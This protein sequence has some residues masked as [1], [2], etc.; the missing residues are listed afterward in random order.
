MSNPAAGSYP[1][2][3]Q[4]V[5]RWEWLCVAAAVF[6]G[7]ILRLYAPELSYFNLHVERDLYRALQLLTLDEIPLLGS[8]M[9][10]GGRVFGP[11]IYF[12]YAI[13]LAFSSSP[14]GVGIFIGLVNTG[15]LVLT[16][17]FTRSYFSPAAG[18]IAAAVYAVFPLEVVQLR[19]LWNPTFL[20]AMVLG[21]YWCLYRYTVSGR[22]WALVGTAAFFAFAL[23]LHFSIVMALPAVGL[24]LYW[25]GKLPPLRPVLVAAAL[26]LV[27]FLPMITSELR[28]GEGNLREVIEAPESHKSLLQRHLPNPNA[29]R[30][31]LHVVTFDWHEDPYRLG[32]TYL[33]P[34]RDSLKNGL[35][36]WF[37]PLQGM[38]LLA[39]LLHLLFWLCGIFYIVNNALGYRRNAAR[40][41]PDG[42]ERWRREVLGGLLLLA[43]QFSPLLSLTFFNYHNTMKEGA[44]ALIPIRYYLI[45]FPAPFILAGIGLR[46]LFFPEGCHVRRM[47]GILG[48]LLLIF[49]FYAAIG[50]AHLTNLARTGIA[51]PYLSYHAPTLARMLE[52]REVLLE[53]FAISDGDYY[54]RTYTWNVFQPLAGEATMDYLVTQDRRSYDNAGLAGDQSI[55]IWSPIVEALPDMTPPPPEKWELRLPEGVREVARREVGR[56]QVLLLEGPIP[57]VE[58]FDPAMKRNFY[59][60]E[61]R[62]RFLRPGGG[63]P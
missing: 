55:L 6:V 16:W 36:G 24:A 10:Y 31:L 13:P 53:E 28:G 54:E 19:Y 25:R 49:A 11:L 42:R 1:R 20:P 51:L 56:I 34:L 43:W 9:Q 37:I 40:W 15:M 39:G 41:N 58:P 2:P 47:K 57:D 29:W 50:A 18:V 14:T 8:E 33:F 44:S 48:G 32:F 35:G 12:I 27:L 60:R 46:Q 45:T 61:E 63:A 38:A 5:P 52:T 62:M 21:M 22:D 30:N 4:A 17:W 7:A 26:L 23:Q 3:E 59:Y